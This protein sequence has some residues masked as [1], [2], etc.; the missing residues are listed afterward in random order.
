ME[1]ARR[2]EKIDEL[3]PLISSEAQSRWWAERLISALAGAFLMWMYV[4]PP[5]IMAGIF[6]REFLGGFGSYLALTCG[7][8]ALSPLAAYFA[9]YVFEA[10]KPWESAKWA[11]WAAGILLAYHW[12]M[13]TVFKGDIAGFSDFGFVQFLN[14]GAWVG[15]FTGF[16]G[17]FT[18]EPKHRPRLRRMTFLEVMRSGTIGSVGLGLAW[19]FVGAF[20]H[21][22]WEKTGANPDVH[23]YITLFT[24][25]GL[26]FCIGGLTKILGDARGDLGVIWSIPP[27]FAAL[28]LVLGGSAN[29]VDLSGAERLVGQLPRIALIQ[30]AVCGFLYGMGSQRR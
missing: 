23:L 4:E 6:W 14:T 22:S 10:E 7:L 3:P 21:F 8:I 24:L 27:T 17:G 19:A 12:V 18:F 11:S 29:L 16:F 20:M 9:A 1:R 30:G 25:L 28:Y 5:F 13:S 2:K 15:V 26:P